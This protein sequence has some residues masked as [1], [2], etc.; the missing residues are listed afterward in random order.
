MKTRLGPHGSGWLRLAC[1][2]LLALG[3][4]SILGV[5][6]GHP[7]GASCVSDDDCTPG[8][9]CLLGKCR[10]G[11]ASE[12]D[13]PTGSTCLVTSRGLACVGRSDLTCGANSSAVCPDGTACVGSLCEATCG[14]QSCLAGQQCISGGCA[15]TGD[16]PDAGGSGAGGGRAGGGGTG[17]NTIGEAGAAGAASCA[18]GFTRDALGNCTD[19]DECANQ[20]A[21]CDVNATCLNTPGSF[22]CTC[23]TSFTGDG[24]LCAR[25]T[26]TVTLPVA[27]D[28][29]VDSTMPTSALGAL[30][31]L[32]IEA[33]ETGVGSVPRESDIYLRFDLGS[34]PDNAVIES[35]QLT[36]NAYGGLA[37]GGDGNVY[38]YFVSNDSWDEATISWNNRPAPAQTPSLGP[39][40]IGFWFLYYSFSETTPQVG[41]NPAA[42][43]V[44]AVQREV[45]GDKLLSLD[46]S[47]PGYQT[48]YRSREF[49]ASAGPTLTVTY[50]TGAT[51]SF[52]AVANVRVDQSLPGMPF[53]PSA[54]LVAASYPGTAQPPAPAYSVQ[55]YVR[56]DLSNRAPNSAI[57]AG[58]LR[59][60]VFDGSP[61]NA[62]LGS[63]IISDFVAVDTWDETKLT[64]NSQP[65]STGEVLGKGHLASA[66]TTDQSLR[67][68]DPEMFAGILREASGDNLISMNL[69]TDD[70]QSAW[71]I[72]NRSV[73]VVAERPALDLTTYACDASCGAGNCRVPVDRAGASNADFQFSTDPADIVASSSPNKQYGQFFVYATGTPLLVPLHLCTYLDSSNVTHHLLTLSEICEGQG[74]NGMFT[75]NGILGYAASGPG[76]GAVGLHRLGASPSS[77]YTTNSSEIAS[78]KG[79]GGT[80]DTVVA[81]VWT[82][83]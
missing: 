22:S 43:F 15:D 20:N 44:A 1:A 45:Q 5:E 72:H 28:A 64:W 58:L 70:A 38:T 25:T 78:F 19:I 61:S 51:Q 41:E 50:F 7:E 48:I 33:P 17:G 36:M 40:P 39:V 37:R 46:L 79:N 81:Y 82:I 32:T 69:S 47:S 12:A 53:G 52:T 23:N 2:A 65:G 24:T 26:T 63:N 67:I 73:G 3:C 16:L 35:A 75:D 31:S 30:P 8:R 6:D 21:A 66:V 55:S 27:A 83:P 57:A 11:C 14:A 10:E 29:T 13:C 18:V 80:I 68:V 9:S 56:F 62:T 77:Y 71:S 54:D 74:N 60:A 42:E 34:I 49:S 59:L 4:S 76:C